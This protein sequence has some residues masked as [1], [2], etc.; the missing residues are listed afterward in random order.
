MAEKVGSPHLL[1]EP[2]DKSEGEWQGQA[3]AIPGNGAPAQGK[4]NAEPGKTAAGM[5]GRERMTNRRVDRHMVEDPEVWLFATENQ[6][7]PG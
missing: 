5:S 1:S 2:E 3:E 6:Q 7:V 4:E